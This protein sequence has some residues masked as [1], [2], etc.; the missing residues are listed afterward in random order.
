M[1]KMDNTREAAPAET[2]AERR[3]DSFWMRA[4]KGFVI[5]VAAILPGASGGVLAVSMGVYRPVINAITGFFKAA[6]RNIL[7]LLPLGL[8]AV[9]GFLGASRLVEWLITNYRTPVMFA[10]IGLVLGGV[11]SFIKEANE[12][13]FKPKYLFGTLLGL[14]VIAGMAL[15][16]HLLVGATAW[17]LNTWTAMA[18][19]GM[20]AA[21]SVIPGIST[22]FILMFV[23]IYEP[24]LSAFN[25]FDIVTL[26]CVAAGAVIVGA[27]LI[28]FVKRMFDNHRGYTYY[29]VLGFLVGSIALIFP[30]VSWGLPLLLYAGM[31]VLGFVIT[32][33]ICKYT[34]KK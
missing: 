32:Y 4:L 3:R 34:E 8:G 26:L 29:T 21:G 15:L 20:L 33:V 30:K 5:G 23:G 13:G 12:F 9:V 14:A 31:L 27:L 17:P 11:P 18:A 2:G 10:L 22:S 6:K 24:L 7:F 19:G 25:R 28:V 1:D 16:E